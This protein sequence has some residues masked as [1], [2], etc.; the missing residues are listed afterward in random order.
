MCEDIA[1]YELRGMDDAKA[2]KFVSGFKNLGYKVDFEDLDPSKAWKITKGSE[3]VRLEYSDLSRNWFLTVY[4][5]DAEDLAKV[6]S[7]AGQLGVKM[8]E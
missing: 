6:V 4:E 5:M 8:K 3:D 7:L 2:E 1:Q